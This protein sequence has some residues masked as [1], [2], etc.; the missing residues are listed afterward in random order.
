MNSRHLALVATTVAGALASVA[1][2]AHTGHG[3]GQGLLAGLAHPLLGLDHLLAMFAAGLWA[4]SLG[5]RAGLAVVGVFLAAMLGGAALA[6]GGLVLPG[7]ETGIAVSLLV[8]G[9]LAALAARALLPGLGLVA[10]SAL[11]HG[12]AHGAELPL[13]ASAMAYAAG[14]LF[15]TAALH[16][17]GI[18]LGETARRHGRAWLARGAGVAVGLAGAGM[19]VAA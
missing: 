12:Q 5:R 11:L 17:A 3:T 13:A 16:G 6:F 19:L 8:M 4:S 14:F 10:A 2:Q 7:V 9:T 15:S 18:A 1:V